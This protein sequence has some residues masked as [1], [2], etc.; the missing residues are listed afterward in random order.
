MPGY[1]TKIISPVPT[2]ELSYTGGLGPCLSLASFCLDPDVWNR[3]QIRDGTFLTP[4][5][6]AEKYYEK[7]RTT[8]SLTFSS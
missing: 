1:R 7:E 6:F 5:A 3:I 2:S 4:F 8:C